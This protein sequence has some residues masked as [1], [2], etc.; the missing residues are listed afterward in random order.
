MGCPCACTSSS[1]DAEG[2]FENAYGVPDTS[3]QK[4]EHHGGP[5]GPEKRASG[6]RPRSRTKPA[7]GA[8]FL[9]QNADVVGGTTWLRCAGRRRRRRG[10]CARARGLSGC[11][12]WGPDARAAWR[13]AQRAG[14]VAPS[15]HACR[16]CSLR[17]CRGGMQD[18]CGFSVVPG[19]RRFFCDPR[20]GTSARHPNRAPGARAFP[21][22]GCRCRRKGAPLPPDRLKMKDK[23]PLRDGRR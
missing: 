8:A 14:S 23:R 1:P 19:A 10:L 7:S 21:A 9:S 2:S 17:G 22:E 12:A 6:T 15:A 3:P 18:P 11:R 20:T 4:A 13:S 16:R 5:V